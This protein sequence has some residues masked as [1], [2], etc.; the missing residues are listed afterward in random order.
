LAGGVRYA[1]VESEASSHIRD[2]YYL[3]HTYDAFRTIV[4]EMDW[5][6]LKTIVSWLARDV[7]SMQHR[8]LIAQPTVTSRE[9]SS[10]VLI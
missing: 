6:W 10:G 4:L 7:L 9:E 1:R 3:T 5:T 2:P 8:A